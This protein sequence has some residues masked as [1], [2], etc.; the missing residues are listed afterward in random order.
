M[1]F[2]TVRKIGLALPGV[3]ES[4]AYGSPALKVRGKLLACV[5]AHRS[6]EPAS[7]VVCVDFD[8]RAEL[9]AAAPD[10]YYVTDH[11]LDY[12]AVLVRLSRVKGDVLRDLLGMA[13][14]FVTARATSRSPSRKRQKLGP[15]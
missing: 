15:T 10:V 13:Y 4:T 3:E 9:L 14:K 8:D 11:Y 6:A 7:L 12:N 1:D 5:P 2:E